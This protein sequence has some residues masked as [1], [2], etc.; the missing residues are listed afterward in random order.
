MNSSAIQLKRIICRAGGLLLLAAAFMTTEAHAVSRMGEIDIRQ[1]NGTPCF[2]ITR[3]E[4]SSNGPPLIHSVTVYEIAQGESPNEVWRLS[5]PQSRRIRVTTQVCLSYGE[6]PNE[7][8]PAPPLK[9]WQIYAVSMGGRTE[10][11]TDSTQGYHGDFCLVPD[12][13]ER[14]RVV[15]I[16]RGRLSQGKTTCHGWKPDEPTRQ[17]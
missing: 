17:R 13:G 11:R 16:P 4:E 6:T 8:A 7:S 14:T 5:L 10:R 1:Q 15:N 9:I 3:E 2:S 12:E